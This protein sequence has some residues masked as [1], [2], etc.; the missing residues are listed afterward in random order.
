MPPSSGMNVKTRFTQQRARYQ[1]A[2]QTVTGGGGVS[3]ILLSPSTC[4]DDVQSKS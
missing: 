4:S 3:A 2:R 1:D